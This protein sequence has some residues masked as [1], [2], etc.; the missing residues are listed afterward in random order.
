LVLGSQ[1]DEQEITDVLEQHPTDELERQWE[2]LLAH[3]QQ[4]ETNRAQLHQRRGEISQ[5]M[6]MLADDRRPDIARMELGCVEQRLA[7]AV[8]RWRVAATTELMLESVREIYES[9][10]QPETLRDASNYL[11]QLTEGRYQRVWTPLGQD[12]LRVDNEKGQSL[13]VEV[14]SR[15]TREAVY[16]SLRL[17]LVACFARRGARM[18]M[19]LDDILVNFDATRAQQAARVLRDFTKSGHQ[20]LMFTC[21]E[22]IV[23][24]FESAGVEVREL[25]R[26]NESWWP[27]VAHEAVP[28][29]EEMVEVEIAEEEFDEEIEEERVEEPVLEQEDELEEESEEEFEE[30]EDEMEWEEEDEEEEEEEVFDD[31]TYDEFVEEVDEPVGAEVAEQTVPPPQHDVMFTWE[32]P[33]RWTNAVHEDDAAA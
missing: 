22:H 17:A 9:Q 11:S 6:K 31:E 20:I 29:K 23:A 18:P 3:V 14:L 13:A 2:E 15:G 25:P 8:E 7:E 33:V 19:V 21:H 12:V 1:F 27:E 28:V 30:V 10:R 5:E 26:H 16:L 4:L 32:S 24:L